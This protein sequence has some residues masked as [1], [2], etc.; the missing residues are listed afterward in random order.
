M[1]V[2]VA[3]IRILSRVCCLTLLVTSG[4]GSYPAATPRGV[5][6]DAVEKDSLGA[7]AGLQAG[8]LIVTWSRAASPPANPVAAKGAVE[9]PFDIDEIAAEQAPRGEVTLF[10]LRGQKKMSWSLPLGD[11]DF[12]IRPPLSPSLQA[13]HQKANELARSKNLKEAAAVWREAA[14]ESE[15]P[16]NA[17]ITIWLL[18]RAATTAASARDWPA[19]NSAFDEAISLS[20]EHSLDFPSAFLLRKSGEALR[21]Q[22]QW[23]ASES[24]YNQALALDR[25]HDPQGLSVALDLHGLNNVK[26]R[27]GD[28]I[29]AQDIAQQAIAIQEKF[30]PDT[31]ELASSLNDL[32]VAAMNRGDLTLADAS[33]R[34]ALPIKEKLAPGSSTVSA[35]LSNL[36]LIAL[37]LSHLDKA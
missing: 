1:E 6:V 32:G 13:L 28:L 18:R 31:L 19:A 20:T 27:R 30:A 16:G 33:L 34:R 12:E 25:K 3:S 10:G 24:R 9:W 8:D 2:I 7:R 26:F 35:T 37:N 17:R 21:K 23:D 14:I 36:G 11:W 4:A 15:S 29:A 22:N 5:I